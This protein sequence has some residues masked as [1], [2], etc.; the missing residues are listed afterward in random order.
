MV[1]W[2]SLELVAWCNEMEWDGAVL[3]SGNDVDIV[4]CM[5][6]FPRNYMIIYCLA[7]YVAQPCFHKT[8]IYTTNV[9]KWGLHGILGE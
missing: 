5:T 3:Q 4:S 6:V 9:G 7:K 2:I 8:T 1:I